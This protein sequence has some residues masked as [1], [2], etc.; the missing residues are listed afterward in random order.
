MR[1]ALIG[2]LAVV[3]IGAVLV[4]LWIR[5]N[6]QRPDPT[7]DASVA[8]PAYS[9]ATVRVAI[10]EAH[11]NFHTAG[12]RYAPFARLLANDG[13]RVVSI[14]VPF[15]APYALDSV[16]VLVIANAMGWWLPRGAR[17][18]RPAF[19]D[20]EVAAVRGWV[21][22]GG[23]LLLVADHYP[24]GEAARA[25]AAAFGVE[26]RGGYLVDG[27]HQESS[28]GSPTWI[29]YTAGSGL[30]DHPVINGRAPNERVRR[31]VAFTGQSLSVPV[32]ATALLRCDTTAFDAMSDGR[33]LPATGRAEAIALPFG[34]GRVVMVGEAAMLTAQVTGGGKLRFGMN[35]PNTDDK[36]FTLNVIH[37]LS[38]LL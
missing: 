6:D 37:W 36:Q 27:H 31:V 7:F 25:L 38:R 34:A 9:D 15:D 21:E 26:M 28:A 4:A 5:H 13:Y 1:R 22:H 24:A 8:H 33:D 29:L 11:H 2:V 17:A 35:W 30:G 23:S 12:K 3:V 20:V 19:R 16:N 32:G 10:D 14:D 18:A